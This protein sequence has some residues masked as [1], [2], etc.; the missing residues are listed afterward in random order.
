MCLFDHEVMCLFDHVFM[1]L[2]DHVCYLIMLLFVFDHV[3]MCLFD[4]GVFHQKRVTGY[5]VNVQHSAALVCN[6]C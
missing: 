2:F 4:R 3:F 5:S 6:T 1:C